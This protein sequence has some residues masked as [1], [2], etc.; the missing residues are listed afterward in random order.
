MKT[1]LKINSI[2]AI[3]SGLLMTIFGLNA[4]DDLKNRLNYQLIS[5]EYDPLEVSQIIV[6]ADER[7]VNI[8]ESTSEKIN[9]KFYVSEIDTHSLEANNESLS[10]NLRTNW[11]ESLV[12]STTLFN[13]TNN[14]LFTTIEISV[15]ASSLDLIKVNTQNGSINVSDLEAENLIAE[16]KNGTINLK[17]SKITNGDVTSSNGAILVNEINSTSLSVHTT[18]GEIKG[19]NIVSN[20][21]EARSANGQ[22]RLENITSDNLSTTTS[23]G[24]IILIIKGIFTEFRTTVNTNNGNIR[25][26][27]QKYN[28]GTYNSDQTRLVSALTSNGSIRLTFI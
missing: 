1:F 16:T 8:I 2:I 12:Y 6:V 11:F 18:N 7:T 28:N 20:L 9:I 23:N 25:I 15:P 3:L 27:N 26:N 4:R 5:G 13:L 14:P 24:E 21:M 17:N 19:E 10:L 22:I